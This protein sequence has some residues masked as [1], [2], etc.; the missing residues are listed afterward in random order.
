VAPDPIRLGRLLSRTGLLN[1]DSITIEPKAFPGRA[2]LFSIDVE[3]DYGSGRWEAL[4]RIDRYLDLA[5]SLDVPLTAFV[6]GQFFET[7]RKLCRLLSAR[8]LDVQLHCY[9]HSRPGDTAAELRRSVQAYEDV[10]QKSPRGYRAHTYRLTDALLT[11]LIGHG[12]AWDSSLMRAFGQGRNRD[13]RFQAGDYLVLDGRLVEF[14][15]ATWG[16]VPVPLNHAYRLLLKT[17]VETLLRTLTRLGALVA[18]NVHMTDLVRC[19]SLRVADRGPLSRLLHRYSWC[20]QGDDTFESFRG[21]VGYLRGSGFEFLTTDDAYRRVSGG[22]GRNREGT[23][24]PSSAVS[25]K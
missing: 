16:A 4:S 8:G 17:P 9:D 5:A 23:A 7:R 12:F 14:P 1:A 10:I 25:N 24:M 22:N 19:S 6:E 2:A 21:I 20:T 18:Y 13:P 15:L 11:G 3:S